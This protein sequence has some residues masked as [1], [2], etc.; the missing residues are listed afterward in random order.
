MGQAKKS[1]ALGVQGVY[2]V[3]CMNTGWALYKAWR[4]R[5]E[6]FGIAFL[7]CDR[8]FPSSGLIYWCWLIG[9]ASGGVFGLGLGSCESGGLKWPGSFFFR[10]APTADACS[11]DECGEVASPAGVEEQGARNGE[12]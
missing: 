12:E 2:L 4:V 1:G 5:Q 10:Q 9:R 8:G 6:E 7:F 11:M 3:R